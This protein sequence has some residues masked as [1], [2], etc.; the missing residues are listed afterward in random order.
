MPA[1]TYSILSGLN[2]MLIILY[3][4]SSIS[5]SADKKGDKSAPFEQATGGIV[6]KP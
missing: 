3:L 6:H 4:E 1:T 5:G 2:F